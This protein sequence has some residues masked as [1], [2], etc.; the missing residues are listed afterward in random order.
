ML[1]QESLSGRG[2]AHF[3]D[4]SNAIVT[5]DFGKG[6]MMMIGTFLGTAFEADRDETLG[7]FIRSL[8]DWAHVTPGIDAPPGVEVRMLQS[9]AERILVYF[10]HNDAPAE[11]ERNGIDLESGQHVE[12]KSLE[13][14]GVWV[15]RS[16]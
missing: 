5:N 4:G 2:I 16:K 9:G 15:V 12:R 6:R 13:A 10:N 14:N 11:I 1:Y 7:K 8:L 3:A